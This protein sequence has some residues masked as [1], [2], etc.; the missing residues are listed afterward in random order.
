V[1]TL[2]YFN[3]LTFGSLATHTHTHTHTLRNTTE[4]DEHTHTNT[5][6]NMEK[7]TYL[8]SVTQRRPLQLGED[9][10]HIECSGVSRNVPEEI[11]VTSDV[12]EG[13][14]GQILEQ[15]VVACI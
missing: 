6:A 8:E 9:G 4:P 10:A 11:R 12:R 3:R 2:C 1:N 7:Y 15:N 14:G 13:Q 5:R